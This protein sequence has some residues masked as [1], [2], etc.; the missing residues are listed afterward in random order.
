MHKNIQN[1]STILIKGTSYFIYA[2][3]CVQY[4]QKQYNERMQN[5][6]WQLLFL[7]KSQFV[8]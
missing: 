8:R 2:G 7:L 5:N 1:I 6:R 3:S 4:V